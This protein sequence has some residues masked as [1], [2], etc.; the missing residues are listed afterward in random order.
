MNGTMRAP[1]VV[2]GATGVVGQGVV[3]AAVE[4]GLPVIAVARDPAGLAMLA[5]RHAE[6][7]L[8]T[9]RGSIADDADSAALAERLRA[10]QRPLGGVVVAV[11][12]PASRGRLLDQPSDVLCAQLQRDV[13]PHLRARPQ[14]AHGEICVG[15]T[16]E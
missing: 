16:Q 2:L 4:A 3:R 7:E 11:A 6:A 5:A 12:G 15:V 13:Q 14:P 8:L 1:I 10:L 9:V